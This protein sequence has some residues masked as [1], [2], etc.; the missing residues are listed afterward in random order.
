MLLLLLL[1][2]VVVV[3]VVVVGREEGVGLETRLEKKEEDRDLLS[4]LLPPPQLLCL[5][6][7]RFREGRKPL[8][9]QGTATPP[10]FPEPPPTP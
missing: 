3:V 2:V 5:K 10:L 6:S 9:P 4:T 7:S 1:L 8:G